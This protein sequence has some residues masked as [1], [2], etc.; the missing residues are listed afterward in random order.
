MRK[1]P[2]IF[3]RDIPLQADKRPRGHP[4]IDEQ[5]PQCQWVFYGS[6]VATEK[7]DGTNVRLTVR[8]G[9]VVRVE[10][11]RNPSKQQKKDGILD[12]W[13]VDANIENAS[14]KWIFAAVDGTDT[15]TIPDG[16]HC[17]EALGPKIN[18]NPLGLEKHVCVP[19]DLD[20]PVYFDVPTEFDALRDWM[21]NVDSVF[22]PGHKIEGI[23]F[24]HE[25]G[26]R[27]KIKR[28]DFPPKTLDKDE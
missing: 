24:H 4:V 27:A 23:V 6:C 12:P 20:P 18:G 26:L 2:T 8:N 25:D 5:N 13:Y 1:I 7:L 10:K 21:E 14:D 9:T 3:K 16:E 28:K 11:R 15:S 22:S 17:C 19:F